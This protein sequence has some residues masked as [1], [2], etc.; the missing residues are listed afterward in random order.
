MTM[1]GRARRRRGS[2]ADGQSSRA[3]DTPRGNIM[4]RTS[5][6]V[7]GGLVAT[8]L[9]FA[10]LPA[11]TASAQPDP[12]LTVETVALFDANALETPENI[13]V[14]N[15]NN[16]YI[17]LAL[18]GEIRKIAPGGSQSTV[19]NLPLGAPP[20]TVCG[21]FFAGLTGIVH[22]A[23]YLYA[24]DSAL[25]LIWRV[26]DEGGTPE[27]WASGE[28]LA[29]VGVGSPGPN[30]LKRFGGEMY[31][32]NPSQATIVAIE[33]APDGSAG[34]FR[35]HATGVFCDDFAFDV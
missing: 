14:D 6:V 34:A 11:T 7:L 22:D 2:A 26:S 8:L 21:P 19:A 13:A 30:G 25:G 20:L 16:K 18:T 3:T 29:P 9:G 28:E 1:A 35:I 10:M 4:H 31:V 15:H 27:I 32:S 24:A 5:Q 12:T 17:S 23:G 33:V